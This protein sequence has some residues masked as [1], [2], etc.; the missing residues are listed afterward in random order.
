VEA[1]ERRL[2]QVL[3]NLLRNA[4][5]HTGP[6][7]IVAVVA[8]A[9][10]ETIRVEVRDTGEGIPPEELTHVW[11][12][13]YWGVDSRAIDVQGAGLGLALV[14]ELTEAMGGGSQWRAR[15]GRGACLQC[16]CQEVG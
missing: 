2:D 11:E 13:F 10:P 8:A 6:G 9:E 16:G 12:R 5:H 15:W 3:T 1:D 7:G 4:V 14:K